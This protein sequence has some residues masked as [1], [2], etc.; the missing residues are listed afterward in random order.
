MIVKTLT[1]IAVVAV[2]YWGISAGG[3]GERRLA[4]R[5]AVLATTL[6]AAYALLAAL[7]LTA[8]CDDHCGNE[9]PW[10]EYR[11]AWQWTGQFWLA[12]AALVLAGGPSILR[13]RRSAIVASG[14]V[15]AIGAIV[16]WILWV[17][18][19]DSAPV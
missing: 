5:V 1:A 2:V 8:G 12:T 13:I 4:R 17:S 3:E 11:E 10:W 15:L 14:L 19:S 9:G 18:P 7:F 6:T 16:S